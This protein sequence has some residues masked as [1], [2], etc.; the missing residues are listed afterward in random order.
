M[1]ADH[2]YR[3]DL[4][5]VL[6]TH[7]AAGAA[8]TAVTTDPP[9]G[10]D[11]GRFAWVDVGDGGR[12]TGFAYKPDEPTGDASAP[13][14]SLSTARLVARLAALADEG[15]S[16]G[17]YGDNLVPGLV[18]E[19]LAVEHRLAGYWRDVGTIA[20]FHA[21][22]M[23]LVGDDR[24]FDLDD[25]AWPTLTGSIASGPARVAASAS[26]RSSLL[27]RGVRGGGLEGSVIGRDVI[28]E[29]GGRRARQ[30]RARRGGMGRGATLADAI[31][32]AGAEVGPATEGEAD[33]SGIT[34]YPWWV[35]GGAS[36][37]LRVA[38]RTSAASSGARRP[39]STSSA[40][41]WMRL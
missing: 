25:P 23:E 2:L 38:S 35:T 36:A 5:N 3:L 4:R 15:G 1:S 21:A 8:L 33:P 19:G 13:R 11:P 10:D 27:G 31:V 14:C 12:I 17:D 22:H 16:A 7:A 24:P 41:A 18:D 39:A 37:W 34:I 20:A 9:A 40:A 32:D 6:A 28:V 29:R 26:I 30:G